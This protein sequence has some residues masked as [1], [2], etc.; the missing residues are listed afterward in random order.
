MPEE[1]TESL[2]VIAD[3]I[4]SCTDC[5]LHKDADNAV[6]GEGPKDARAM[7][8]GQ[9]PGAKEDATGRPFVGPS[10][11]HLD[12]VLEDHGIDRTRCYVTSVVKHK[13]PSNRKP[14]PSE[15]GACK[16]YLERQIAALDP[17]IVV[18][19]G[20][21]AQR[22]IREEHRRYIE[23]PHPAA[24]MRFP[25]MNEQFEEGVRRLADAMRDHA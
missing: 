17:D 21:V 24:A 7:L 2:E 15:V 20:R 3:D 14:R 25:D 5:P 11:R 9:N 8:V 18:L 23:T 1:T 12:A 22:T 10:G 16:K 6:P 4:A 13:T 19:M